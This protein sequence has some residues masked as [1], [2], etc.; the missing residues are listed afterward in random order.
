M[1]DI[2]GGQAL[3]EARHEAVYEYVSKAVN[4]GEFSGQRRL[5]TDLQLAEKFDVS[6]PTVARAMKRLQQEGLI[7]RKAGSGTFVNPS[8]EKPSG[9]FGLIIPELGNS[10][11]FEPMYSQMAR[12]AQECGFNLL[13]G[14]S[15]HIDQDHYERGRGA[16]SVERVIETCQR[17]V[18]EGVAGV[19]FVPM[20]GSTDSRDSDRR[21]LEMLKRRHTPVVLID[22][23]TAVFPDRSSYDLVAVDHIRG[24]FMAT[25]H[26]LDLGRRRMLFVQEEGSMDSLERRISGFQLALVRAGLPYDQACVRKGALTDPGFIESIVSTS[27]LDAIVCENDVIAAQIIDGLERHGLRVPED[28]SV[29]GFNDVN[30]SRLFRIPLTSVRQP[31]AE[32]GAVAVRMMNSRLINP[33]LPGRSTSIAPKL[34]V[35]DSCGATARD[36]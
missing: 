23:D 32:I 22:R 29:V 20:A 35:R 1:F 7:T 5:P 30:Y 18:D 36:S 26:L 10:E 31:C 6:R 14:D 28:C 2:E 19:F 33:Q 4:S 3:S 13:L 34:I 15:G 17:F 25:Q 21:V 9:S 11:I 24:Q 27:G 8:R 16:F 12:E